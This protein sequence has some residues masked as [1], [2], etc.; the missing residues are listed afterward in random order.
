MV[1]Q[2]QRRTLTPF[3]H[4]VRQTTAGL[5][6]TDAGVL[7]R[8]CASGG[9]AQAFLSAQEESLRRMLRALSIGGDAHA[10]PIAAEDVDLGDG[11]ALSVRL[12]RA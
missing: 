2:V 5:R 1:C 12:E 4:T 11:V 10:Q 9:A 3:T 8:L 6:T 7:V